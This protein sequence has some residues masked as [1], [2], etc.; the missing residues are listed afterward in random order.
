[1]ELNLNVNKNRSTSYVGGFLKSVPPRGRVPN[2]I[3]PKIRGKYSTKGL[4]VRNLIENLGIVKQ[5]ECSQI[6]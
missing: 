6:K 4:T 1:V 2:H 3:F 5:F